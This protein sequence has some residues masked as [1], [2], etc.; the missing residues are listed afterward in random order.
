MT[1]PEKITLQAW[2]ERYAALMAAGLEEPAYGGPVSRHV[3]DGDFRY[4]ITLVPGVFPVSAE[5]RRRLVRGNRA[6]WR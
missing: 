2:D 3:A 1:P 4:H 6:A 5:H